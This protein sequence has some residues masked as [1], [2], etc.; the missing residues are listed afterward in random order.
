MKRDRPSILLALCASA[1][2]LMIAATAR[3]WYPRYFFFA[4]IPFLVL[5]A[6]F[7]V[8][9]ADVA[10]TRLPKGVAIAALAVAALGAA[11]PAA[12]FDWLLLTHPERAPLPG[13]DRVQYVEGWASGFG[14]REAAQYVRA[15]AERHPEGIAVVGHEGG[16]RGP[17]LGLRT[18]LLRD[19]RVAFEEL[20]LTRQD[21]V[22]RLRAG[23]RPTFIVL[24]ADDAPGSRPDAESLAR[25]ARRL[26]SFHRPSGALA[27]QLI[28]V[29]LI[30][31]SPEQSEET[32]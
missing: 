26:E 9:F 24:P 25:V 13:R 6:A 30:S 16:S 8:R 5:V 1:P 29:A 31:A 11:V 14:V 20:D 10:W 22:E 7:L 32:R 18:Y 17:Y 23:S 21:A 4:T 27:L 19:D 28:E 3:S 12:R 2:I 15:Q